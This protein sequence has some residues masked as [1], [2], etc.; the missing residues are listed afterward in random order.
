LLSKGSSSKCRV[1]TTPPEQICV[2]C[3]N[4]RRKKKKKAAQKA[5]LETFKLKANG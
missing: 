4:L 1:D 3:V 5:A 2:L